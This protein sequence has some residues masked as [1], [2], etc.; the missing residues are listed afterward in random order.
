M[1]GGADP[2]NRRGMEWDKATA[3]N[4][5]LSHYKKLAALKKTNTA[6]WT[7]NVEFLQVDGSES[8]RVGAYVRT[9]N[10]DAVLVAY[11]RSDAE[12]TI[13]IRPPTGVRKLASGGLSDIISGD[14]VAVSDRPVIIKLRPRSARVLVPSAKKSSLAPKVQ[15]FA[16]S[17]GDS[18]QRR[19]N[20]IQE[21][22][23]QP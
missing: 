20:S 23:Q 5:M 2:D 8:D 14:R 12:Q 17:K 1:E 13:S 16:A 6:L 10:K 18:V 3:I 15:L 7:P 22:T 9:S 4:N 11:N 21:Q 19:A